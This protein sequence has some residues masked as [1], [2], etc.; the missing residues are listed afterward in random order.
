MYNSKA[1][2]V[3]RYLSSD[4]LIATISDFTLKFSLPTTFNDPY[5]N[6]IPVASNFK[7]KNHAHDLKTVGIK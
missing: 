6:N 4:S 2:K 5:D 3:F 7:E 1:I